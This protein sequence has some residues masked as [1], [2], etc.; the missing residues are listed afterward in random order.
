[1][2]RELIS[3]DSLC[4]PLNWYGATKLQGEH[5][6]AHAGGQHLILRTS[7]VYG[8][9]SANFVRSMLRLGRERE[10]LKIVAD[11]F[12]APSS[13]KMLARLSW[14]LIQAN[15]RPGMDT[16]SGIYHLCAAGETHWADFA[17]EIFRQSVELGLL[18]RAPQ[19]LDIQTA[20]FPT[21][22]A[23]QSNSR[24]SWAKLKRDFGLEPEPWQVGLES[25][26]RGLAMS[27]GYL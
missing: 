21:K 9:A 12:G 1:M 27:R 26:L 5:L 10:E 23:R 8:L 11:Q 16:P 20:D 15:L 3:E 17:R 2:D 13:A 24:L 22:A 14:E 19:V 7:W 6:L 4:T 25:F 18:Q